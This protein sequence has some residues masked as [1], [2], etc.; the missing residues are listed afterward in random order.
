MDGHITVTECHRLQVEAY[1]SNIKEQSGAAGGASSGSVSS[2]KRFYSE[3]TELTTNAVIVFIVHSFNA[4][5]DCKHAKKQIFIYLY[6]NGQIFKHPYVIRVK[7]SLRP[8]TVVQFIKEPKI[9]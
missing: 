8:C 4:R 6:E 2:R 1:L 3:R 5:L 9:R 7:V